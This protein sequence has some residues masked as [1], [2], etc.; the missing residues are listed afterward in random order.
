MKI[1]QEKSG[2]CSWQKTYAPIVNQGKDTWANFKHIVIAD[3]HNSLWNAFGYFF[4]SPE[5]IQVRSQICVNKLCKDCAVSTSGTF[6]N[7]S[8]IE[9]KTTEN[10][11]PNS[12]EYKLCFLADVNCLRFFLAMSKIMRSKLITSTSSCHKIL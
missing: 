9:M 7:Y 10:C 2:H 8:A 12:S 4:W 5:K 6:K 11:I 3:D 1:L